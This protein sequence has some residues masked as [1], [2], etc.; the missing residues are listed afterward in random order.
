MYDNSESSW[1]CADTLRGSHSGKSRARLQE[2]RQENGNPHEST[3]LAY[4]KVSDAASLPLL[5]NVRV[6]REIAVDTPIQ[7]KE[8]LDRYEAVFLPAGQDA[9]SWP[10]AETSRRSDHGDLRQEQ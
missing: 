9:V 2:C 5:Q 1:Q 7:R 6:G 8:F 3:I 4:L 10:A